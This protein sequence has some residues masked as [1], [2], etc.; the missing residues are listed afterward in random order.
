MCCS[1]DLRS[2]I[3]THDFLNGRFPVQC[4]IIRKQRNTVIRSTGTVM[5][6]FCTAEI[7]KYL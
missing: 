6:V 1:N 4:L 7:R 3:A 5:R 2:V